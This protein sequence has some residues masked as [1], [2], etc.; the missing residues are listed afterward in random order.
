[1]RQQVH[2]LTNQVSCLKEE[3]IHVKEKVVRLTEDSNLVKF[4]NQLLIEMVCEI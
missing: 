2:D 4:K 1:M 3:M